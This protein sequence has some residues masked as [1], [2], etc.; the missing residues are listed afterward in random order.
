MMA[1]YIFVTIFLGTITVVKRAQSEFFK[2]EQYPVRSVFPYTKKAIG[3]LKDS[4]DDVS[5]MLKH[6][7][8]R[9]PFTTIFL[10]FTQGNIQKVINILEN[11]IK[12]WSFI[13][14]QLLEPNV[15]LETVRNTMTIF[16]SKPLYTFCPFTSRRFLF[17]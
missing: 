11:N 1:C 10:N 7:V 5:A 9:L 6:S 14:S 8:Y 2:E 17:R 4:F 3:S 12:Q 13:E 15:D 16:S